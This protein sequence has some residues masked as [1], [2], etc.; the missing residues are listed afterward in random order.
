MVPLDRSVP[1]KPSFEDYENDY[2]SG[3]DYYGDE[4]DENNGARGRATAAFSTILEAAKTGNVELLQHV[5]KT[6]DVD[7][8]KILNKRDPETECTLL[9]LV[10][11]Q[12]EDPYDILKILLENGADATR[13]SMYNVQPMHALPVHCPN[14]QHSLRLLLEYEA[15]INARDGDRWVPLHYAARFCKD[16]FPVIQML[17]EYGADVNAVDVRERSP[18]FSLLA[19]GDYSEVLDWLIHKA[20]AN[21]KFRGE[22]ME[23]NTQ[24]CYRATVIMQAIM[25]SRIECLKVLTTSET[26][27]QQL[28]FSVDRAELERATTLINTRL[29]ECN[30]TMRENAKNSEL[31]WERSTKLEELS[32][33]LRQ[34]RDRLESDPESTVSK[35]LHEEHAGKQLTRRSSLLGTLRRKSRPPLNPI[36]E[37]QAAAEQQ[38]DL[39][40]RPSLLKRVGSLLSRSRSQRRGS[41]S[42]QENI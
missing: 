40:R 35:E 17:V 16:P 30:N 36:S 33:I 14:P 15:D 12:L 26:A 38:V 11:H 2:E 13:A 8:Y 9:H 4:D 3:D 34:F 29:K 39:Q 24:R 18:L 6:A 32:S 41:T 37:E 28:R 1:N 42:E 27:Y 25:H 22:F 10:C 31:A 19:N 21:T 7:F 20:K 23:D 5:I